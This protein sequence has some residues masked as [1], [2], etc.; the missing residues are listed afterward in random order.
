M[1]VDLWNMSVVQSA[2]R[3]KQY[4]LSNNRRWT[5]RS[6]VHTSTKVGS[7]TR[8]D[9]G[10]VSTAVVGALVVRLGTLEVGN[11]FRVF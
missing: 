1:E 2:L 10:I 3:Q 8:S 9:A 4:V 6:E 11:G 5:K 7:T